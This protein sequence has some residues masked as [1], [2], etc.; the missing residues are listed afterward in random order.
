V[1]LT[2]GAWECAKCGAAIDAPKDALPNVV[3]VS[4]TGQPDY[5]LIVFRGKELHRCKVVG[6]DVAPG[7]N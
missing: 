7:R 6:D 2:N 4:A 1:R 5:R 3:I